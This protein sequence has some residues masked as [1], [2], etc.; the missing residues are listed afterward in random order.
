MWLEAFEAPILLGLCSAIGHTE[1]ECD[2]AQSP[3]PPP[4]FCCPKANWRWRSGELVNYTKGSPFVL[5]VLA[6]WQQW[7]YLKISLGQIWRYVNPCNC[8][9]NFGTL[10][11][12]CPEARTDPLYASVCWLASWSPRS[13]PVS[14]ILWA[15]AC[16]PSRRGCY[17]CCC[18]QCL[19]MPCFLC[20]RIS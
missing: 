3:L 14:C 4:S 20:H 16:C 8:V 15:L 17:C 12:G 18:V 6:P 11:T 9:S 1:I 7:P 10:I 13:Q 2:I 5:Q 19:G